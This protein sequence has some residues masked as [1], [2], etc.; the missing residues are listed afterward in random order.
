MPRTKTAITLYRALQ[1]S[2][3]KIDAAFMGLEVRMPL[4]K[5]GWQ[6]SAHDW[7][8]P[9]SSEALNQP[10]NVLVTRTF[11]APGLVNYQLRRV[12]AGGAAGALAWSAC[13]APITNAKVET[14]DWQCMHFPSPTS[15]YCKQMPDS[16]T[17]RRGQLK[18]CIRANFRAGG[19]AAAEDGAADAL[20][21]VCCF[22]PINTVLC[23]VMRWAW[24]GIASST[25]QGMTGT[26][27]GVFL[28]AG[29]AMR[30][31]V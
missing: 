22:C 26:V 6:T 31:T 17:F 29:D 9:T 24:H 23:N 15:K 13:G 4:D 25:C 1:K 11:L 3:R 19:A 5:N 2:A 30:Y 14:L 7:S 18:Q 20:D 8:P 16:G 21:V 27:Q 28:R 10:P 12:P